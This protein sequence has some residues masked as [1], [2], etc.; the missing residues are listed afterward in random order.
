MIHKDLANPLRVLGKEELQCVKFLWDTLDI[1]K[2]IDANDD[3]DTLKTLFQL[4][5]PDDD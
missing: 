2:A 1:V 4:R 5:D 3:F